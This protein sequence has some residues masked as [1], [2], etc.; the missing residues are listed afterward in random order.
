[1]I[2]ASGRNLIKYMYKWG[3]LAHSLFISF[4]YC[5]Y[6]EYILIKKDIKLKVSLCIHQHFHLIYNHLLFLI[7]H[8][9]V[10]DLG[11]LVQLMCNKAHLG[12]VCCRMIILVWIC[13]LSQKWSGLIYLTTIHLTPIKM[14]IDNNMPVEKLRWESKNE[15]LG[16]NFLLYMFY[17]EAK[18]SH[19]K[20]K[21]NTK[22][23]T[24]AMQR[25]VSTWV[26][27]QSDQS[28]VC[29]KVYSAGLSCLHAD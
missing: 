14:K 25:L 2:L 16:S 19:N 17:Y 24:S 21:H 20:T 7:L 12:K 6:Y 15:V 8:S 22:S 18:M 9:T 1:M 28:S 10:M 13:I 26:S 29:L 23:S 11:V 27:T 5:P 4:S 3:T